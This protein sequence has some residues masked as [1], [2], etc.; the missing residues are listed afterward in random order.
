MTGIHLF[1][2]CH[3]FSFS[4]IRQSAYQYY[5][6]SFIVKLKYD[7]GQLTM[8][9]VVFV[10]VDNSHGHTTMVVV[11]LKKKLVPVSFY[12][13]IYFSF[14]LYFH[15]YFSTQ[16]VCF[17]SILHFVFI[18]FLFR[19]IEATACFKCG[20]GYHCFP[21][22]K[23]FVIYVNSCIIL[24]NHCGK[25]LLFLGLEFCVF[26][27]SLDKKNICIGVIRVFFRREH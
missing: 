24:V 10:N 21:N 20:E 15:M 8:A 2:F 25:N 14:S 22:F 7:H 26:N 6:H 19:C 3:M 11:I 4:L 23:L 9:Q 18:F 16:L 13:F 5:T 27:Y 1:M 17:N 12:F